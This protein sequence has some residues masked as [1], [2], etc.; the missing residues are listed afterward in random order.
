MYIAIYY[1]ANDLSNQFFENDKPDQLK[2]K[3]EI[4]C[5]LITKDLKKIEWVIS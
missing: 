2:K 3:T 5:L 1:I 4:E